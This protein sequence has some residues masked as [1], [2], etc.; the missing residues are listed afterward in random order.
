MLAAVLATDDV[1]AVGALSLSV[2]VSLIF[3]QYCTCKRN[4]C[5]QCKRCG[6]T[7]VAT[8]GPETTTCCCALLRMVLWI[9]FDVIRMLWIPCDVMRTRGILSRLKDTRKRTV[10]VCTEISN[11]SNTV[12]RYNG[13]FKSNFENTV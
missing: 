7:V 13:R 12:I 9:P 4:E 1:S 8:V 5:K 6:E 11:Y 10:S 3:T 2:V